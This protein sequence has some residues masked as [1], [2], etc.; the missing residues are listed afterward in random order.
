M[1]I[2]RTPQFTR[3]LAR[4]KDRAGRARVAMLLDRWEHQ[5]TVT[6]DIKPVGGGVYEARLHSGPGYRLY[7]A[8][9]KDVLVVLLVGGDKR[10]QEQDI[11]MSVNLLRALKE[12]GQ[13]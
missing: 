2:V 10:N 5:G 4:L 1:Q 11:S 3:W 9:K 8:Q 7:F 6:G 12:E 13:W